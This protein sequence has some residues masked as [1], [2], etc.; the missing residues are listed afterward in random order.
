MEVKHIFFDLDHTLWDFDKNSTLAFK[1]IFEEQQIAL[2]F[3]SFL[4]EYLPIN[5]AYWRLFREQ[6]ISQPELR[7][8]RLKDTFDILN[9]EIA[10]AMIH[11]ISEDYIDY[12]PNYNYLI[13][14]ALEL[15]SYLK[16]KYELH[17]I[18]NGFEKVQ[19]KKLEKSDLKPYFNVVVTSESIGVKKPN[20]KVFEFALEK[21]NAKVENSVMVGDSFEADILGSLAVGMQPIYL[22][23]SE[24]VENKKVKTVQSL[25][26]IKQFL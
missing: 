6:R 15:L 4:K 26:E 23:A 20:P 24:N 19:H 1:Q 11:R 12:L 7:Y 10:D 5:L 21:A 16:P 9:F 18:T 22:S 25:L 2:D 13:D 8:K 17:M 3:Q 14:G